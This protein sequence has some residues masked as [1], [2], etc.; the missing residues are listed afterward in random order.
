MSSFTDL[1]T[2]VS[3]DVAR[4]RASFRYCTLSRVPTSTWTSCYLLLDTNV[5][6]A[7]DGM[8]RGGYRSHHP[9]DSRVA[10]LLRR[11]WKEEPDGLHHGIDFFEGGGFNQGGLDF[12]NAVRRFSSVRTLLELGPKGFDRF[13]ENG[14]S[15]QEVEAKF[16]YQER[17]QAG[18]DEVN[19]RFAWTFLPAYAVALI[20]N[21]TCR[22]ASNGDLG[23][24][25][26]R[27][28]G[29]APLLP[30]APLLAALLCQ[31]GEP[32]VRDTL[33]SGVFHL[34]EGNIAKAAQSAAWDLT[35]VE[36]LDM[37]AQSDLDG[38]RREPAQLILVTD[39]GPFAD[40]VDMLIASPFTGRIEVSAQAVA[41]ER[42]ALFES[43][44]RNLQLTFRRTANLGSPEHMT[45]R[46]AEVYTAA[47][48]LLEDELEIPPI[49]LDVWPIQPEA[50]PRDW[51]WVATL[52]SAI[53]DDWTV[54]I[55]LI[56]LNARERDVLLPLLPL[57]ATL[58]HDNAA[59]R[60]RSVDDSLDA[61]WRSSELG[62]TR[63]VARGLVASAIQDGPIMLNA[64]LRLVTISEGAF[65]AVVVG[66][67]S[68]LRSTI[69]DSAVARGQD[70]DLLIGELIEHIS[71][72]PQTD[73]PRP[74][75]ARPQPTRPM[76]G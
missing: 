66:V 54:I 14:R 40:F 65:G 31:H 5:V 26:D 32:A 10:T 15:V 20:V 44:R 47:I 75:R 13:V 70:V 46:M 55:R 19:R 48:R 8:A 33:R 53:M 59:A 45:A 74:S 69:R 4:N 7:M 57:A 2:E 25:L 71:G 37:M 62:G 34:N 68:I 23:D 3:S 28:L 27:L 60:G 56:D 30:D 17:I 21:S 49:N 39:D 6:T 16:A 29:D 51:D 64:A 12:Y 41:G 43:V 72:L 76:W 24:K 73:R 63:N 35:Y 11:V 9:A 1:A 38:R 58:M 67:V 18:L 61:I 22:G 42:L 50:V 36:W 52:L